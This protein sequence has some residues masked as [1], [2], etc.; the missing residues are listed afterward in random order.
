M[1]AMSSTHLTYPGLAKNAP[2]SNDQDA[3]ILLGDS[4]AIRQ[5]RSQI[6]RVAP[7]LR[8]ALIRGEAGTG[9]QFVARA[10]H[11]L[12]SG[13]EGPFIVCDAAALAESIADGD[14]RSTSLSTPTAGQLL[15]SAHGGILFLDGV[16]RLSPALQTT[17]L[18]FIRSCTE[19]RATPAQPGRASL[20]RPD[21]R[22]LVAS[23]RDLRT[24]AAVGH[25]RPDLYAHL[26]GVELVVPPLRQRIEDIPVLAAWLLRRLAGRAGHSPK[27]L[28]DATLAQ[29][30][31]RA[32][33][34]NLRELDRVLVQAASL[35]DGVI[36]EPRHLLALV[37]PAHPDSATSTAARPERLDDVIRQHVLEVLTRCGGNK[38]RAAELLGI[39]RSTLYRMLE[40]A[41]ASRTE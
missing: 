10:V 24:L 22:I 4:A 9:K 17:L 34:G 27:M 20:R 13:A 16:G 21:T 11:N 40:S 12:S 38:L 7:Y 32:W 33:P 5:L 1:Q 36:L 29:L 41:D 31:D 26:S 25:F 18:G 15:K 19:R 14:G 30:Q 39:S 6:Q 2:P 8:I 35:T 23:D 37:E 3:P 28:A